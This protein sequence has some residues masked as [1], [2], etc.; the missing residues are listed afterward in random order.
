[1]LGA[2]GMVL[3]G[4]PGVPMGW[5]WP[6]FTV[7]AGSGLAP[8]GLKMEWSISRPG[9]SGAGPGPWRGGSSWRRRERRA[10]RTGRRALRSRG[11][12]D[13]WARDASGRAD[14][15]L[16]REESSWPHPVPA[17]VRERPVPR[18]RRERSGAEPGERAR[19]AVEECRPGAAERSDEAA[20]EGPRERWGAFGEAA[21]EAT[22]IGAVVR[23][24][25]RDG[26]WWCHRPA[27]SGPV[28]ITGAVP[29]MAATGAVVSDRLPGSERSI[30][31]EPPARNRPREPA[32]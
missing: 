27:G 3:V 8:P 12:S 20:P 13:R 21:T 29:E 4:E 6:I 30:P 24:A 18:V 16:S 1:M 5:V 10:G 23:C 28:G 32:G 17:E 9:R 22:P 14:R 11:D 25:D 26:G 7:A 19:P 2:L 15:D 31:L